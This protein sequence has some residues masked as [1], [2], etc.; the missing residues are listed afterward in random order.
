MAQWSRCRRKVPQLNKGHIWQA[1]TSIILD[2]EKLNDF[3]LRSGTKTR[4][5]TSIQGSTGSLTQS[6]NSDKRN[7]V[8]PNPKGKSKTVC[9]LCDLKYKFYKKI[10]QKPVKMDKWI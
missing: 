10:H 6:S 2:A 7:K 3:P 8:H 9:R 1:I 5:P 4:L